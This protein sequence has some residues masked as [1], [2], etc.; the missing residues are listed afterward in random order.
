MS[1]IWTVLEISVRANNSCLL[2]CLL[3]YGTHVYHYNKR[4]VSCTICIRVGVQKY[5]FTASC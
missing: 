3:Q 1:T 4:P 2:S 5:D